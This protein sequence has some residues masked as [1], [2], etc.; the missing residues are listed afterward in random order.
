MKRSTLVFL[1]VLVVCGVLGGIGYVAWHWSGMSLSGNYEVRDRFVDTTGIEAASVMFIRV[2][3]YDSLHALRVAEF[4]TREGVEGGSL[5]PKSRRSF[6]YHFFVA[7]DTAQLT[8]EMIDDLAYQHPSIHDP[9][10]RLFYVPNGWVVQAVFA[11]ES[12]Q[13]RSVEAHQVPFFM[14]R[15]GLRAKDLQ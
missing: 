11:P 15:P 10:A 4:L 8:E 13:P 5:S 9:T 7:G 6:L 1:V 2:D 12:D 3:E 14:P